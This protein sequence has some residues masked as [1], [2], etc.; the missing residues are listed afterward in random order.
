MKINEIIRERR[1][2]IGL[3]QE[4]AASRLGVSASAFN[5][6][7]RAASLPDIT[8]LPSLA[9]LLGVDLNTLLDF[10]EELSEAEIGEFVNSLDETV[11]GG[12][13]AGA[14][15]RAEAKAQEYP[16]C[17]RLLLSSAYYL[18]G[19]LYLYDVEDTE[20]Y[21][22]K[23]DAWYERLSESGDGDVRAWALVM[24]ISRCRANGDLA[25]AETLVNAL[26]KN[27]V[28]RQEQLALLYTAQ[29]RAGEAR[30]IWQQRALEGI[31]E[32]VTAMLH[33]MED[34]LDAG[35]TADAEQ[36]AGTIEAVNSAAG[37]P[38]WMGLS[39][40]LGLAERLGER[41]KYA[42]ALERLKRSLETPW[43][44]SSS[45]IYGCL[46]GEGVNT[47]TARLHVLTDRE[48]G[49]QQNG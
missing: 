47:L 19:A 42:S 17:E 11:R 36:I 18:E 7:E 1:R 23:L 35:R 20:P 28:D 22:A 44:T 27:I 43:E 3:T 8:L 37:L 41:E 10:S 12:D 30:K 6:W 21:R 48:A 14:F 26:P 24:V 33:L 9:R 31:S 45:P 34:A 39:A 15:E 46:S 49:L 38:E 5:K 29:G 32:S 4:Q 25:R 16:S 2:A 40:R 13:Y